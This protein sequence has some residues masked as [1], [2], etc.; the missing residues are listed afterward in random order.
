MARGDVG[1]AWPPGGTPIFAATSSS[2]GPRCSVFMWMMR[3]MLAAVDE[4]RLDLPHVLR[5]GRLT[6]QQA[7]R[8]DGQDDRDRDQ[9]ER[10]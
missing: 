7:L 2:S 1:R 8:L 5:G 10:R 6:D 3:S 9:Q 4:R